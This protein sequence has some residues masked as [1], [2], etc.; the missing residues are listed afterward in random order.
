V[1]LPILLLLHQGANASGG[2]LIPEQAAYDVQHY[3]LSL[4]VVPEREHI[5]GTLEMRAEVLEPVSRLALDLDGRLK[6]SDVRVRAAA[7]P[8]ASRFEHD[9]GRIWIE[10][11]TP[12]A[13]GEEV[14]LAVDYG[15]TPRE[16]PRPPWDGGFT[17]KRTKAGKPWI[18]TSCQG[19]G[20]DLWWPCKDHPS[21]KPETMD[22]VVTV[23]KGL[24][25]ASNGV[26]VS[27]QTSGKKR[28]LHW[29]VSAPISNYN[30]ALNIAPYE[31][32][33]KSY[34]STGGELVPVFFWH[35][36]ES[37]KQARKALPE[38]LEHLAF[39]EELCGPYPFRAEK[40][41]IVETPHLGMEHQ[42]IIAYGNK[43]AGGPFGYDWLH[44]HELSHEW[45]A[46]LV[47]CADWKDMWLHEGFGTYMQA[48]YAERKLGSEGLT[49][50]MKQRRRALKNERP[51]APRAT[52]NSKQIYFGADGGFDNDIYDKG[53]WVL[54]TLRWVMGD[55]PFL[56]AL[57]RM[58]YPDPALE[59]VTD[60][61]QVR[62]ADTEDFRAIAEEIHGADLSWFFEVYLR[63]P[64]LP[65]LKIDENGRSLALTWDVPVDVDFAM[66][67]PVEVKGELV[68]V[69]MPGGRGRLELRSKRYAVD[70]DLWLL[71]E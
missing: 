46:N 69:P 22:I 14:A 5:E 25:C 29:R 27:D 34:E 53:A 2:V 66:P 49:A 23:P 9:G 24:F 52:Q 43:F 8:L 71:R 62:F 32:L 56:R 63:Q 51:V 67:V 58:A 12:L 30:V 41:G 47:T 38:F 33:E 55:E 7:R 10:V 1:L 6:V 16:A 60:G 54:H 68:R 61:S 13:A 21:D 35:L 42:T 3:A 44:H 59:E 57:R 20:G 65:R 11:E 48:L 64:E 19:E 17:W 36:P 26:L 28:T 70:P 4:E 39:L 37:R 18:A 40:Y 50:F 31:V 15:G 45:W